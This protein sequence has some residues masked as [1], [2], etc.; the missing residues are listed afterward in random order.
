MAPRFVE[1]RHV[2][3]ETVSAAFETF[4]AECYEKLE[5]TVEA[6]MTTFRTMSTT[7][8]R[9]PE[10]WYVEWPVEW[11]VEWSVDIS[12]VYRLPKSSVVCFF[13][14]FAC[15]IVHACASAYLSRREWYRLRR[16]YET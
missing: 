6:T 4:G 15:L 8:L 1:I 16:I 12:V 3:N 7:T 13:M 9:W 14:A 5:A 10:E 11:P 2:S